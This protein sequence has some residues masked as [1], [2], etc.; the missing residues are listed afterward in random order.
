MVIQIDNQGYV[1]S[2]AAVGGFANGIEIG[3]A[4]DGFAENYAG[5]RYESGG[6]VFDEAHFE[7]L[8][9]AN[10]RREAI[11]AEEGGILQWFEWYDAQVKQYERA[12]RLAEAGVQPD[13]PAVTAF[14]HSMAELDAQ[15]ARNHARLRELD[16]QREE[17]Q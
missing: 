9:T 6:L 1:T 12:Q 5:Y 11:E 15:A 7:S 13:P 3:T 8:Q 2:Y 14:N 16:A 4:P 10:A 17:G